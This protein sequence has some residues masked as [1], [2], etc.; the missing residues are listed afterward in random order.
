VISFSVKQLISSLQVGAI[1]GT[2]ISNGIASDDQGN[3]YVTGYTTVGISG[4]D[5]QGLTDYIIA[6]YDK[7]GH[8]QWTKEVGTTN[9]DTEANGVAV[10]AD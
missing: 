7:Q 2:T 6:K 5:K 9:G 4:Q 8:L 1:N 3:I 10:D